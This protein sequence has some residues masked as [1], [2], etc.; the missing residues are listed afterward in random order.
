MNVGSL[1]VFHEVGCFVDLLRVWSEDDD[2]TQNS[3]NSN[4]D[5]VD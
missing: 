5:T 3:S 2:D 4:A 1:E